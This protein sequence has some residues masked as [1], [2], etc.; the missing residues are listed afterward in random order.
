MDGAGNNV[1]FTANATT[2]INYI[3]VTLTKVSGIEGV[4]ADGRTETIIYSL[5]GRRLQ[6][7][8]KGVN[9][10]NGKKVLVK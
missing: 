3:L 2:N 9:I 10:V 4:E 7:A 1:T 5:D 6:K 8:A